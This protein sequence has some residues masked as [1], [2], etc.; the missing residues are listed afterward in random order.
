MVVGPQHRPPRP[1]CLL[2]LAL[3]ALLSIFTQ[4][5]SNYGNG[6]NRELGSGDAFVGWRR[7]VSEAESGDEQV[8]VKV[9][10]NFWSGICVRERIF[11][12]FS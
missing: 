4:T 9:V 7:P 3:L 2:M 8:R 11:F 6:S 10:K 12:G 5:F 1:L